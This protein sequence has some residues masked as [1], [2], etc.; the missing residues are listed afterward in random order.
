MVGRRKRGRKFET[1]SMLWQVGL[2]LTMTLAIFLAS[3]DKFAALFQ[4][5]RVHFVESISLA[6][7]TLLLFFSWAFSSHKDLRI[8][9]DYLNETISPPLGFQPYLVV[10]AVA[11]FLAFLI[12]MSDQIIIYSGAMAIY[13]IFDMWAANLLKAKIRKPIEAQ[14]ENNESICSKRAAEALRIHFFGKPHVERIATLM[15]INC[16]VFALALASHYEQGTTSLALR[17]LAYI[18]LLLGIVVEEVVLWIWRRKLYVSLLDLGEN[19]TAR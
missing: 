13:C 10:L 17:N 7:I 9:A 15:F 4:N 3:R 12:N 1:L 16:T 19:L 2:G 5:D 14:I 6:F 18:I 8:L 11:I